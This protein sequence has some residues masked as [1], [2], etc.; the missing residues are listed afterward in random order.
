MPNVIM[1]NA[2]RTNDKK[3][4][5]VLLSANVLSIILLNVDMLSVI[6]RDVVAPSE[7]VFECPKLENEISGRIRIEKLRSDSNLSND[8]VISNKLYD[9]KWT[10]MS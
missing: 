2:T 5:V 10:K 3:L 4:I 1:P 9:K 6:L 7:F 8:I